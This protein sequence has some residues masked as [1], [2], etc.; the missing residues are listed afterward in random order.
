MN[1]MFVIEFYERNGKRLLKEIELQ[2]ISEDE[3]KTILGVPQDQQIHDV[4]ALDET[5]AKALQSRVSQPL[6]LDQYSIF[7]SAYAAD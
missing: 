6:D 7:L 2:P 1:E 3:L 5:R 4:Y